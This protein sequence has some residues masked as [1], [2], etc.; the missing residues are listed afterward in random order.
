MS[1]EQQAEKLYKD[2]TGSGLDVDKSSDIFPL[3]DQLISVENEEIERLESVLEIRRQRVKTITHYRQQS[4][5][6]I[7]REV[8]I[9]QEKLQKLVGAKI[10]TED[11]RKT[12]NS[13]NKEA[14]EDEDDNIEV[15]T[16]SYLS[17]AMSTVQ[18]APA[19]PSL[20]KLYLTPD[21]S[22][23]GLTVNNNNYAD[24]PMGHL[25]WNSLKTCF[26]I[27][28]M[29]GPT[30][31]VLEGNIGNIYVRGDV[32]S[33]VDLCHR[34]REGKSCLKKECTFRHEPPKRG[35]VRH[36]FSALTYY[37][38]HYQTMA[39]VNKNKG[40]HRIG[41]REHL[42]HD[43]N[44]INQPEYN[45]SK[46]AFIDQITSQFLVM[47]AIKAGAIEPEAVKRLPDYMDPPQMREKN[48]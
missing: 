40:V 10:T 39:D 9:M 20:K 47:L 17:A 30:P 27:K 31:I 35:E 5:E 44:S 19:Q 37:P 13:K 45:E 6:F 41:S 38:P 24:V 26:C 16:T 48:E 22:V 2:I 33:N 42:K 32:V 14:P 43:L 28:L 21:V 34:S 12:E 8:R 23:R 7:Q 29:V 4:E 3:F 25:F 36:Y 46:K 18:A 1:A 11:T 15:P